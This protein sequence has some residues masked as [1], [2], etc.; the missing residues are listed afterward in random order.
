[1]ERKVDWNDSFPI[2]GYEDPVLIAKEKGCISI[3]MKLVLP[4]IY[5]LD[6]SEYQRLNELWANVMQGVGEN[7]LI[8][9]QDMFFGESYQVDT[10]R[11]DR[12]FFEFADE[13]HFHNRVYT[14]IESYLCIHWVPK[15]YIN[16]TPRSANRYLKKKRD[17]YMNLVTPEQYS[18]LE[19][20]QGFEDRI[21]GI[22]S[23][24]NESGLITAKILDDGEL[25]EP[26]G[27]YDKYMEAQKGDGCGKDIS[28][29]N[30][31]LNIG[32]KRGQYYTLESLDQFST[33]HIGEHGAFGKFQVGNNKFPV[34]NLFSVGYKFPYEHILNQ[35]VYVPEKEKSLKKLEDQERRLSKYSSQ[36]KGDKNTIYAKQIG[37]FHNNLIEDHKEMVYYH[38]NVL[39][40]S[41]GDKEFTKMTN[42]LKASF[43]KIGVNPK[44]NIVDRKNLFLGGMIGNGIGLSM[45]LFS[46]MA[47]DM[48]ASLF[49]NEGGYDNPSHGLH[50]MRM[51]DRTSGK[52]LLVSIYR[53]PEK[54]DW[55]FNRGMIVASGS[56]G[57]KTYFCNSY[58]YSELREG[59]EVIMMENGNSYDKLVEVFGGVI[60]END[61]KRPFTFNPF[62]L[63]GY[64]TI[65]KGDGLEVTEYKRY[66]IQSIII[67]L[68][69]DSI[70]DS[71]T[72]LNSQVTSRFIEMLVDDF[73]RTEL[74]TGGLGLSFNSFF[75]FAKEQLPKYLTTNKLRIEVFDP[76]VF[77]LLLGK[78][79]HD[80]PSAYLLNSEDNRIAELSKER[81]VYFKLQ[82]LIENK[83]LF[84]IV[85]FLMMGLFDK[86]LMDE[87]KL[88]VNKILGVDEAW[89][90]FDNPIMAKYFDGQSRMARKYGGQPIFIS[91][92][93]D[94]FIKSKHIGKSLVVNSHIKALLD[95]REFSEAFDEIQGILGLNDKQKQAILTIN[96]DKPENR[97]L[98]EIAICWKGRVK[99]FGVESSPETKCIFETNA[100]EKARINRIHRNNGEHWITTASIY[101]NT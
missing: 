13:L 30:G 17:Y 86:K 7:I 25:F 27:Y 39:G 99:V 28:F 45:D 49:Y 82:N 68:L 47:S 40:L 33:E 93:V 21:R 2:Y 67:L 31:K 85:A 10:G 14:E 62:V 48:A 12:D 88:G 84:P 71:A 34:S 64:D 74:G 75:D 41:K 96:R 59:A 80:G 8:H 11:V 87:S 24:I 100:N 4:E 15:N 50:G 58:L 91:Q 70:N 37:D 97:K 73:Y 53:E 22:E 98:R 77:L 66:E 78:F 42:R 9:K 3:P 16:R 36:R 60:I 65:D 89:N 94:D 23:M 46:P 26:G 95:L 43:K 61:P 20:A 5:T 57:G 32:D 81:F 6:I 56:G 52:P 69:G 38:M 35:Y 18:D 44:E 55:I 101:A 63:D 19:R 90:L 1:M 76:G 92:K 79:A 29:K 72:G 83:E 51:V 54:L